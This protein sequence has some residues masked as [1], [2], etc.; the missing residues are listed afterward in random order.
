MS[1]NNLYKVY[2]IQTFLGFSTF[3]YESNNWWGKIDSFEKLYEML[4]FVSVYHEAPLA[5]SFNLVDIH[6]KDNL[7]SYGM[8]SEYSGSKSLLEYLKENGIQLKNYK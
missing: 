5:N 2:P 8:Y 3:Y 7:K 6:G 1:E 4:K